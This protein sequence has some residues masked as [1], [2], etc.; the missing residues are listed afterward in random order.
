MD[1]LEEFKT[2]SGLTPSLPKSTAYFCNVLNYVKFNIIGILPFEEGKLPVKYL[3]VPL[4]LSRLLYRDSTEMVEKVKKWISDWKNKSLSLARRQSLRGFLWCQGEIRKG[5]A[6]VA[7]EGVCLPKNEG[8][9]SIRRLEA[10]NQALISSYLELGDGS[11]VSIWF[12]NWCPLSPL[13]NGIS[14]RDIYEVGFQLSAKVNNVIM[15]GNWL[16]PN[17]WHSKFSMLS[18]MAIPHLNPYAN[19]NLYWRDLSNVEVGFSVAV[20]WDSIRPRSTNIN[21]YNLVWLS[22]F[23][24]DFKQQQSEMTNKIDRLLKAIND[25]MMG[26]LPSDMLKNPKLNVNST[27][28]V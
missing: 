13:S 23:E 8:G 25:R 26:E 28:S 2:A 16:W 14:N 4:V 21:W 24:V 11:K 27:F 5:K 1:T 15:N 19:D 22:K 10:F 9:L 12:D 18:N 7:W 20:V 3:G 17:D 6:K